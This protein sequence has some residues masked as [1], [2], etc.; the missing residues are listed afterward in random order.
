MTLRELLTKVDIENVWKLMVEYYFEDRQ[1]ANQSIFENMY[2]ELI[3][4]EGGELSDVDKI[5]IHTEKYVSGLC[6][7]DNN[8]YCIEYM[9]W[10]KWIDLEIEDKLN[11]TND[12]LLCHIM[13]EMSWNGWTKQRNDENIDRFNEPFSTIKY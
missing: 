1:Y 13:W 9:K 4:L 7:S 3:D 10:D 5:L 2:Y 12:E 8:T 11:L 6:L